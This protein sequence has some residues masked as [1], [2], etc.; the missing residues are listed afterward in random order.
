M[1]G[2]NRTGRATARRAPIELAAQVHGPL[3]AAD[4]NIDVA[5]RSAPDCVEHRLLVVAHP[6]ILFVVRPE[7]LALLDSI[8]APWRARFAALFEPVTTATLPLDS[9]RLD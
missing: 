5:S 4:L 8:T 3:R 1:P 2:A 9:L 6:T 7:R